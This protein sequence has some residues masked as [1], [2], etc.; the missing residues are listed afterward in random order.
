MGSTASFLTYVPVS[1]AF[2]TSGLRGLVEDITDLEAYINVR[3]AL[4]YLMATG[5]LRP[6]GGIVL[7]GDLRPS[8]ERIMRA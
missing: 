7:A 4:R 1:L 2:G 6:R 8:T 3:G 5:D